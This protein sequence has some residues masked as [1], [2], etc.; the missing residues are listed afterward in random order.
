MVFTSIN[1][2]LFLIM[3]TFIFFLLPKKAKNFWLLLCSYYFY[4]NWN[5]KYAFLMLFSTFIT[6]LSGLLIDK[7]K[8]KKTKKIWVVTSVTI[9]LSILILFKYYSFIIESLNPILS[10]FTFEIPKTLNLL[11]PVGISFY[12]FQALSYTIDVYRNDVKIEKNFFNYALFVS[13]FPQLVAG[14]IEKSKDLLEQFSEKYKFNWNNLHEG[15]LLISIGFFYKLV[16]ADRAAIIVNNIYNNVDKYSDGG[17]IYFII[18]TIF[19]AFQIYFDFNAYSTI[20]KGSAKI[21][22]VNLSTNFK[23]PYLAKSIKDFWKRWHISLSSW[24]KEYL[25]FPIGGNKK[26]FARTQVNTLIIFL[27]SGLWHGASWNFVVWGALHGIFQI[28]ENIVYKYHKKDRKQSL[29]SNIFKIIITFSLVDFS[30][31]F[32]RAN[33]LKDALTVIAN[34]FS[35]GMKI[36]LNLLGT[37]WLELIILLFAIIIVILVEIYSNKNNIKEMF[38][39]KNIIIRWI[40]YYI[41]IF[42]IIIFGIYGPGYSSQE[43]IYF[44]F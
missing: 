34:L 30:W 21:M 24:F 18:A 25:Y 10:I 41:L 8:T 1:Y 19:F 11:L 44:Q 31:I 22:G 33:T 43:F 23:K 9:N 32:F 6:Y 14:P 35:F 27:V 15:S 28:I 37:T 26:G 29:L 40:F 36:N 4:I 17:G 3:V 38:Y 12:T 39:K 16:I 13:Y 5:Y 7:S 42:S 2:L 20:A